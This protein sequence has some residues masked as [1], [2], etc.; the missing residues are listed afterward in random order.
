MADKS[1]PLSKK[2][3]VH[4]VAFD[5]LTVREPTG[6]EYWSIGPIAEWQPTGDG[7]VM[8]SHRDAL[9]SYA[10]RLV[11]APAGATA[12]AILAVLSLADTLRIEGALKG[13]F[14]EAVRLNEPP[15]S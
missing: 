7:T 6:A 8:V 15:T 9:R 10:E 1:V 3:Q 4:G 5:S 13:F 11:E 2:Y 14:T 12:P